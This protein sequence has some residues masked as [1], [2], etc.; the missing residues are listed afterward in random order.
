MLCPIGPQNAKQ[1]LHCHVSEENCK[2]KMKEI[3]IFYV[4]T[5]RDRLTDGRLTDATNDCGST[6]MEN[7]PVRCAMF[8]K[9][10]EREI[11]EK[12]RQPT[13]S[14]GTIPTCENPVTR[15]EIESGSPWWANRSVTAA[16]SEQLVPFLMTSPLTRRKARLTKL[17]CF[18]QILYAS[19]FGGEVPAFNIGEAMT[20]REVLILVGVASLRRSPQMSRAAGENR[21]M[22]HFEIMPRITLSFS[23]C[24]LAAP[25]NSEAVGGIECEELLADGAVT[26]LSRPEEDG[27][28]RRYKG[29]GCDKDG[30][31]LHPSNVNDWEED[32]LH[33]ANG[34][35]SNPEQTLDVCVIFNT[36]LRRP[37]K[38]KSLTWLCITRS[39]I[40]IFVNE[41]PG[42]TRERNFTLHSFP[43]SSGTTEAL[44][45]SREVTHLRTCPQNLLKYESVA[46]NS[47]DSFLKV[48]PPTLQLREHDFS[49][50][51]SPDT[52]YPITLH[53]VKCGT[54]FPDVCWIHSIECC[55]QNHLT[56]E[57]IRDQ[58][59]EHE[60]LFMDE[61][62][63]MDLTD[64][65]HIVPG[66]SLMGGYDTGK[67][68]VDPLFSVPW[69]SSMGPYRPVCGT[70]TR[71]RDSCPENTKIDIGHP[72]SISNNKGCNIP[73]MGSAKRT[74]H[75]ILGKVLALEE[76]KLE[77]GARKP[78]SWIHVV[79][80]AWPSGYATRPAP[81]GIQR[82]VP[83]ECVKRVW[84]HI[85]AREGQMGEPRENPWISG[86]VR[87][88]ALMR[89][90]GDD[91]VGNRTRFTLVGGEQAN[92]PR[93]DYDQ[94]PTRKQQNRIRI[95]A[96]PKCNQCDIVTEATVSTTEHTQQS[97][98]VMQVAYHN[99]VHNK[100]PKCARPYQCSSSSGVLETGGRVE[101]FL[102]CLVHQESVVAKHEAHAVLSSVRDTLCRGSHAQSW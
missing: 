19:D 46:Q 51:Q 57:V 97:F 30:A 60:T 50:T 56:G 8:Q 89:I 5:S 95:C 85:T 14:S 90:S 80:I 87:H 64:F 69:D 3:N 86:N 53:D 66:H 44:I 32:I 7:L 25:F 47:H 96:T 37:S 31:K 73:Y 43:S 72:W 16:P 81:E 101:T 21:N 98:R 12:T 24:C 28:K 48:N 1:I 84:R 54:L 23:F 62:C 15:P 100:C 2:S 52:G 74:L 76:H 67:G 39:R 38:W 9:G 42:I 63:V 26:V 70:Q 34:M 65:R 13:A 27:R 36:R 35:G 92:R 82:G 55:L 49:A 29:N 6:L 22:W 59:I 40:G 4:L 10:G 78:R 33:D 18:S 41:T 83:A 45:L 93:N 88:N 68:E 20:V 61:S 71:A 17:D 77:Y 91:P 11:P 102:V 99:E 79:A 75:G 58:N 94:E